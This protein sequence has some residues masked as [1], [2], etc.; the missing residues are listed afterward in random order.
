[1]YLL[2]L[3]F[4]GKHPLV[5]KVNFHEILFIATMFVMYMSHQDIPKQISNSV[6]DCF[7]TL[8]TWLQQVTN[9]LFSFLYLFS[10]GTFLPCAD[11]QFQCEGD[12][13]CIPLSFRCDMFQDCGDNSDESNCEGSV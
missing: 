7:D 6:C 2:D 11:D 12:G 5:L 10:D 4:A 9:I 13:K 1:M 3:G 8:F